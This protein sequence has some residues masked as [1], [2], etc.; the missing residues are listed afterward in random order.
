VKKFFALVAVGLLILGAAS[1]DTKN[2]GNLGPNNVA[3][4]I[5]SATY[6]QATGNLTVTINE[7]NSTDIVT[8]TCSV[9]TGLAV[10]SASKTFSKTGNVVFH[11]TAT[12]AAAGGSGTTTV[13]ATDGISTPV[14]TTVAI[15]VPPAGVN[16]APT[17]SATYA[18]P[19]L[20]VTVADAENNDVTVSVTSP[21]GLTP[22]AASKTVTGGNGTATFTWTGTGSGTTTITASDGAL[23][24]TAT[25][26]ITIGVVNHAPTVSAVYAEPTLTV[27]VADTDN[28]DV[29]VTVTEPVG[30]TAD[31]TSK[32]VTGG[33]G[34]TTF[35]WTGTG[36]GDTT[37]TA[38]DG[39]LSATATATIVVTPT[40]NHPPVI[41]AHSY[42]QA[43]AT[44]SVSFTDA[45]ATDV[46]NVSVTDG[47]G[48]TT[49][50]LSKNT[51][52]NNG[53]VT[54]VWTGVGTFLTTI[55]VND[56]NGGTVTATDTIILAA[57][58]GAPVIGAVTYAGGTLTVPITDPDNNDVTV[59]VTIPA[60]LAVDN[61]SKIVSPTPGDAVFAWSATDFFAGGTGDT[62]ITADDGNGGTATTTQTI[63]I[64]GLP[65]AADTLYA[66]PTAST[67]AVG[68]AVNVLV[69]T[70][71]PANALQF[72]SSVGFTVETAG[73]YVASSFNVGNPGGAR[74]DTDGYWSLLGPP[75]PANGMYLDLGDAL[76]PGAA[77]DIGGGVHRYN[78]AV[79]TQG[80]FAAPAALPG[81]GAILY[82]FQLTFSA[83]GTYHLGFQLNDGVFDQT[84]YSD[85]NGTN[86]FWGTLDASNTITVN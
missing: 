50:P 14:S 1:C 36:T 35:T 39:A 42:D 25:A 23:S 34:N 60:G 18:E 10:D 62:T 29:T 66:F 58:N 54:F 82:N 52:S 53:T 67:A 4:S 6:D 21:A 57:A 80:P 64:T 65:V 37:I 83:P 33:N 79:V 9:P 76:M 51:G 16:T 71:M 49:N 11:W 72:L 38:S 30:L 78:F 41:S 61:V 17:V 3:P 56:G 5:T 73:T 32:V 19:T 86:F 27:T 24:A 63:T 59:T 20:T 45:D 12:D 68:D 28:N 74:T 22:D 40:V 81:G 77:T 2:I 69:Y 31:A 13:T 8:V 43:T 84:Y 7:P 70:G 55:T 47:G 46:P 75:A 85:Q 15:N 48:V 26:L 44:L